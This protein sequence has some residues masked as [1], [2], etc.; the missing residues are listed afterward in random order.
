MV[1]GPREF[2]VRQTRRLGQPR[3]GER[4]LD[5]RVLGGVHFVGIA[6][7]E[8]GDRRGRQLSHLPRRI[9][10]GVECSVAIGP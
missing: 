5:Q 2:N 4:G 9:N 8:L 6:F 3:L 1:A 10:R 7:H